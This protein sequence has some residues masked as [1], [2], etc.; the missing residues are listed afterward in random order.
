MLSPH[1]LVSRISLSTE[2]LTPNILTKSIA[3]L[4][5]AFASVRP[6]ESKE[7]IIIIRAVLNV[8]LHV[9]EESDDQEKAEH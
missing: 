1:R 2:S 4:S 3:P 6:R 7:E 8:Q 9:S 5:S